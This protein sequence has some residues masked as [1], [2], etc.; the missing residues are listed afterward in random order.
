MQSYFKTRPSK[1]N[2]IFK[3]LLKLLIP[4]FIILVIIFIVGKINLPA[5]HKIIKKQ[6]SNEKL[7]K[8][9]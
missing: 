1:I 4:V 8:V 7:I 3:L 6:I 2:K 9:K 5:P